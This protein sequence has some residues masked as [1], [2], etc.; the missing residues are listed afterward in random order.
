MNETPK[1]PKD[2]P[3]N[4]PEK[5]IQEV[6]ETTEVEVLDAP[7][8]DYAALYTQAQDRY[9]RNLAEFDNFRK[10]TSKEMAARYE[11]GVRAAAEK[12]LP[13][14]DNFERAMTA[15]ENKDDNFYQGIAMIARQLDGILS[16]LGVE[17]ICDGVGSVFDH[18]IHHAVA[19]I[20]DEAHGQNVV[21]EVLQR[22]YMHRDKVLRPSMVKVAN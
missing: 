16:D 4:E 1:S 21:T 5:I 9:Q 11:D 18:N 12:L 7:E 8:T 6:D 19:H 13:I 20:Q 17:P 2:E 22:G 15:S 3:N 14:V 10:R